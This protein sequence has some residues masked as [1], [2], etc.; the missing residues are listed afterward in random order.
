MKIKLYN[1]S[2]TVTLSGSMTADTPFAVR[3]IDGLGL[4]DKKFTAITLYGEPGRQTTNVHDEARVITVSADARCGDDFQ[5]D[6]AD[7]TAILDGEFTVEIHGKTARKINARCEAFSIGRRHGRYCEFTMQFVCDFPYFTD[8]VPT[9]K[10]VHNRTDLITTQTVLPAVFTSRT[11][12]ADIGYE[13]GVK[14]APVF[15][16][17]ILSAGSSGVKIENVTHGEKI[18]LNYNAALGEVITIDLES[19]EVKNSDG[20]DLTEYISNDTFLEDFYLYPGENR[21]NVTNNSSS[22]ACTVR[23]R[24]MNRYREGVW[25]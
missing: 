2:K 9:V 1:N 18:T 12:N 25:I 23:C 3:E 20:D 7:L 22:S 4:T 14:T 16:V 5:K 21:I 6:F 17:E 13:G 11:S 8:L 19:G 15:I 24:Y 10:G